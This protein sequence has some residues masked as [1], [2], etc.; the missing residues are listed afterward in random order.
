MVAGDPFRRRDSGSA[1]GGG[2]R[3]VTG[4]DGDLL[5]AAVTL[6]GLRSA[7]SM[8]G[9]GGIYVRAD[10]YLEWVESE[11]GMALRQFN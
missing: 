5:L 6:R 10:R 4:P 11:L 1:D 3:Y 8:S 2:P 9:D 7:A